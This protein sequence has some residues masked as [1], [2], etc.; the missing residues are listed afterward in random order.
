MTEM[1]RD[2]VSLLDERFGTNLLNESVAPIA[3]IVLA[4]AAVVVAVFSWH[5]AKRA[6]NIVEQHREEDRSEREARFRRGIAVDVREW[7]S[8]SIWRAK[9]GVYLRGHDDDGKDL[10]AQRKRIEA[11]LEREGEENGLRLMKLIQRRLISLD[12]ASTTM[13]GKELARS[14]HPSRLYME[15]DELLPL[16]KRWT[17][18]PASIE[19]ELAAEESGETMKAKARAQALRR[20][21]DKLTAEAEVG[22]GAIADL[23]EE[24]RDPSPTAR[25]EGDH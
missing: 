15:R 17:A 11:R 10:R 20:M 9:Y 18:D 7:L 3:T 6:N 24:S 21:L 25:S 22:S 13:S 12:M 19:T 14:R 23:E 1:L 4:L 2:L 5:T 16:L 8:E